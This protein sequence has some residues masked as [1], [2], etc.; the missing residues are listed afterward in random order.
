MFL[1]SLFLSLSFLDYD[2]GDSARL[3][4]DHIGFKGREKGRCSFYFFLVFVRGSSFLNGL[5]FSS[6]PLWRE[7]FGFGKEASCSYFSLP[8]LQFF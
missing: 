4:R 8:L 2:G 3:D 5:F 1:L 7:A 6:V